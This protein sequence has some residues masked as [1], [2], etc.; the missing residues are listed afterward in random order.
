VNDLRSRSP[1]LGAAADPIAGQS[2]TPRAL[3]APP[4][5]WDMRALCG[6]GTIGL[7]LI[8]LVASWLMPVRCQTR[9]I[10]IALGASTDASIAMQA[11]RACTISVEIGPA[12]IRA[13]SIETH[14][15]HG[16]LMLR[17]RNGIVYV[18]DRD[19]K[20]KDVFAFTLD[21]ATGRDAGPALV[22][23]AATVK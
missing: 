1:A 11:G 4:Q 14:P 3:S 6:L 9:P 21:S 23:V 7:L 13:V 10:A 5:Q 20:G 19:F 15:A 12:V 17:G 8:G 2:F 16:K 18:P 22:R